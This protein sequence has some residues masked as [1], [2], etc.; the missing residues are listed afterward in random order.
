M[1]SSTAKIRPG[2]A[3][4]FGQTGKRKAAVKTVSKK[5]VA[6]VPKKALNLAPRK[7]R[8]L[9]AEDREIVEL[10]TQLDRKL[11]LLQEQTDAI[12]RELEMPR[13]A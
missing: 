2:Q 9:S 12:T 11:D 5:G 1:S 13:G 6:V 3:A 4:G 7:R 10:L 8:I